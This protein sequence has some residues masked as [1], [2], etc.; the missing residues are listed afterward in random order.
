MKLLVNGQIVPDLFTEGRD[1]NG[2]LEEIFGIA[3]RPIEMQR[4]LTDLFEL[5][6]KE[7]FDD[8]TNRLNELERVLGPHDEAVLRAHW[9]LSMA[10]P[11]YNPNV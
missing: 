8:A 2:L 3:P 4:K 7:K 9:S 5:I 1:T 6:D 10:N 11:A